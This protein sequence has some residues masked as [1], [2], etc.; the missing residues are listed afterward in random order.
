MY[1]RAGGRE[2][3]L[4]LF[5][6]KLFHN[7]SECIGSWMCIGNWMVSMKQK[8]TKKTRALSNI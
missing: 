2:A 6:K 1:F 7:V 4:N 5:Q 8:W 3:E